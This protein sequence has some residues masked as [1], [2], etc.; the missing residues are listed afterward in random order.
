MKHRMLDV[1]DCLAEQPVRV[2][3]V[4]AGLVLLATWFIQLVLLGLVV[5]Q[6]SDGHGLV[7]GQDVSGFNRVAMEQAALIQATGWT[8]WELRPN[9]WGV[10]GILSAWYALTWPAPWAFAPVQALMYGT[11]GAVVFSLVR[12]LTGRP[13]WALLAVLP[14]LLPTAA[15]LYAQ[16]HRDV[17][18]LFGLA[19]AIGGWGLLIQLVGMPPGRRWIVPLLGGAILVFSGFVVAWAVRAFTAEIFLGI[20]VLMAGFFT[21]VAGWEI[22]RKR[23]VVSLCSLSVPLVA[24]MLSAGMAEFHLGGHFDGRLAVAEAPEHVTEEAVSRRESSESEELSEAMDAEE[25]AD[26]G[27]RT[28]SW[29]PVAIDDRL[30]RLSGARE[31][32]LSYCY[33][34]TAVD[35][36]FFFRSFED[37]LRYTPRATQIGLASPFPHQ[38]LPHED[39]PP[40]RNVYRVAGGLEMLALYAVLPFVLYAIWGWRGRPILWVMLIPALSWVMVYAYAVPVVGALLRYRSSAYIFILALAV[41]GLMRAIHDYRARPRYE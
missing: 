16:P 38:W 12:H 39:A 17:F 18:V 37:M 27:W 15:F 32:F 34:R 9:G 7:P 29:L 35:C 30:R 14:M 28:S 6:W 21:L 40:V 4:L 33:A 5:P 26:H 24:V 1:V 8:A 13:R 36:D 41:A 23:S 19:L 2:G 22:G 20:S 31:H 10:S 11:S 25:V 3:L